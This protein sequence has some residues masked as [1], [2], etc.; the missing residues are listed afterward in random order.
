[1]N[2][3]LGQQYQQEL[4]RLERYARKLIRAQR[5]WERQRLTVKRLGSRMDKL[6]F[7]ELNLVEQPVT[8]E[9]L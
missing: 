5:A 4:D 3:R 2:T 1:M 8:G 6:V 9:I 7:Q